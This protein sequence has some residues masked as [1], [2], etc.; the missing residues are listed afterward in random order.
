MTLRTRRFWV[1]VELSLCRVAS[2]CT[3]IGDRYDGCRLPSAPSTVTPP[4]AR[5]ASAARP[6]LAPD[7]IADHYPLA[8][9]S[10]A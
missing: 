5:S 2:G 1:S 9:S 4:A 8:T 6:R 10:S 7:K 3:G